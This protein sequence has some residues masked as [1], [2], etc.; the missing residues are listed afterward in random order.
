MSDLLPG[1]FAGETVLLFKKELQQQEITGL[2]SEAVLWV[3]RE[4][5][6]EIDD[7]IGHIKVIGEDCFGN[8]VYCSFTSP[9][10]GVAPIFSQQTPQVKQMTLTWNCLVYGLTSTKLESIL[11]GLEQWIKKW[12]HCQEVMQK[13]FSA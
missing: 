3:A 9:E 1:S 10:Q 5:H 12:P 7:F 11:F 8:R 2:V 4:C 6:K 13:S